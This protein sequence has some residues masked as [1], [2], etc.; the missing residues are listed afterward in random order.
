MCGH[1]LALLMIITVIVIVGAEYSCVLCV[2]YG[3]Q[4]LTGVYTR[5]L[6]ERRRRNF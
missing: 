5:V 6:N 3:M 2:F 1:A 4:L